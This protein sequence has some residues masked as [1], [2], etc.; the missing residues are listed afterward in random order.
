MDHLDFDPARARAALDDF[1][2]E[3][4]RQRGLHGG[5]APLF[6]AEKAGRGFV[7]LGAR[8]DAALGALHGTTAGRL[9]ELERAAG[10]A[11]SDIEAL[12]DA[13][14]AHTRSLSGARR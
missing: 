5:S 9:G 7:E 6:P 8:L 3:V 10:K 14:D 1:A 13:D 4:D 11:R 2:R 12:V